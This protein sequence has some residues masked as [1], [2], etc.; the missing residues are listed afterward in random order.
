MSLCLAGAALR[1]GGG[2]RLEVVRPSLARRANTEA[3]VSPVEIVA[4]VFGLLCVWL[5]TR[6]SIWCWPAGLVNV[7]LSAYLFW[8]TKLYSDVILQVV[9]IVLQVYGWI[10]WKYGGKAQ[11]AL[12]VTRLHPAVAV[13]WVVVVAVWTPVWGYGMVS[14]VPD[15]A[16]P[17]WDAGI[18]VASLVAQ[19]L[20]T[21]K[22]VENWVVWMG[23]DVVAVGVYATRGLYLMAGLYAVFFVLCV[24]GLRSWWKS[25]R[26]PP[27]AG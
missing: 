21:R 23:V 17:Y 7:T 16:L 4:V 9:Y 18:V 25:M 8:Q 1:G 22:Y 14:S 24:I 2:F 10:H 20:M 11:A 12:P 19:Y 27:A 15:V 3:S 5:T 26:P 6:Q 13:A